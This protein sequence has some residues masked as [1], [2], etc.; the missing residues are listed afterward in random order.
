MGWPSGDPH[1]GQPVRLCTAAIVSGR[2][3]G[4]LRLLPSRDPA[5][6]ISSA[7]LDLNGCPEVPI[8]VYINLDD[9]ATFWSLDRIMLQDSGLRGHLQASWPSPH[10][11]RSL[12]NV[13]TH[14]LPRPSALPLSCPSKADLSLPNLKAF[15]GCQHPWHGVQMPSSDSSSPLGSGISSCALC[16]PSRPATPHSRQLQSHSVL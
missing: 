15:S 14:P 11:H 16:H 9:A 3:T 12:G 5:D 10:L 8:R 4:T 1:G 13:L 7:A 6:C 2:L